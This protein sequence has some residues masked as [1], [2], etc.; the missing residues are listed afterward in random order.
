MSYASADQ[1][2]ALLASGH[3]LFT[4]ISQL[5][6]PMVALIDGACMGGG[7]ELALTMDERLVSTA[8]HTQI[9]LPE[10][11]LG[12]LPGWGGTQ[13]LPRLIGLNAGIDM[14][15]S[16][17]LISGEKA[18]NLGFAFDAVPA[19]A[20]VEE[21]RRLIDHMNDSRH[22]K[23]RR[24]KLTQPLGLTPDQFQFAFAVAEGAIKAKTK[25]QYPAP[26][27]ALKAIKDGCNLPLEEGL[28]VERKAFQELH[29]S[30]IMANLIAIFFMKNRLS[31]DPGVSDPA[32]KPRTVKRV[33]VSGAGLMGSGIVA[34]HAR[35]GIPTAMID[36]DDARLQD[37]LNRASEVVMSRIKIGRATPKDLGNM[38]AAIRTSTSPKIFADCDVV[39]EA[40]T[41]NEALK[42][43]VYKGLAQV[44]RPDAILASNTSTISITRMAESAPNPAQFIGMHFFSP[45]DRMELVE[46]IRGAKTSD[47]TVAT[48]VALSKRIRKTP[49]VVN[50][51]PGFLVN[52]VLFP[53]MNESL[54]LLHEGASMDAVDRAATRFGMPVGPLLLTDM[55][56]LQTACLAGKVLAAAFPDRSATSPILEEMLKAGPTDKSK[57]LKFWASEGKRSRPQSDPAVLAI[58]AKHRTG[59]RTIADDEITDRLFLPMLVEATRVLEEKIVREP[60]DVD[61][62][63]ILGIGFPPFR[64][65]ILRWCDSQG[66]SA[67]LER[68]ARYAH[69]GKRYEPTET[70]VRLARTG[71]SFY[72]RPKLA[73]G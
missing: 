44:L 23:A 42:K 22:W 48:I 5:P 45:V 36:I 46:I 71:E 55:V 18:V 39:I 8:P 15:C 68:L 29:G 25:G 60:A 50:D 31:R 33:G 59:N 51:C 13:R 12:L 56:G 2:A 54:I 1:V 73:A 66:A 26:L 3:Q 35:S 63:L 57:V 20:L 34:A 6:F 24:Q 47:E 65:G 10:V 43:E 27:V 62:G 40:V 58:I 28:K 37:G 4:Q 49:I 53:Y 16:S 69:L 61:M 32:V 14:V 52:R 7:T 17:T 72:P 41:E 30:P 19:E 67:V 21:G 64:G 9:G 70:L 11:G 38:L